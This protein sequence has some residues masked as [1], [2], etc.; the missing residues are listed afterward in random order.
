MD[1]H[2]V[3]LEIK[4]VGTPA[5]SADSESEEATFRSLLAVH[6]D[7]VFLCDEIDPRPSQNPRRLIEDGIDDMIGYVADPTTWQC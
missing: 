7:D 3:V 5:K 6:Q 4:V 1:P 2:G